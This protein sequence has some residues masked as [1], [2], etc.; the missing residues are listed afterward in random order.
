MVAR[1]DLV[2]ALTAI[3][4]IKIIYI[5]KLTKWVHPRFAPRFGV[6]PQPEPAPHLRFGFGCG[7]TSAPEPE[8]QCRSEPGL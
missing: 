6:Q 8:V 1:F 4:Y 3:K 2:L 7:T 5:I